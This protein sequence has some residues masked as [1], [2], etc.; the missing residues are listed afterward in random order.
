MFLV[1][2]TILGACIGSFLNVVIHRL[3]RGG[4]RAFGARSVCPACKQR[5]AWSDNLPILG[6]LRL[7]GKARCCGVR[8]AF[9]YPLVEGLTALAFAVL[10][11]APPFGVGFRFPDVQATALLAFVFHA[12][13][14]SN[15]LANT[16]IDIDFRI[17][18]DVLTFQGM[19]V[20]LAGSLV[21]PGL[22]GTF[23]VDI[24]G[25]ERASSFVFSAAGLALGVGATWAIR[26][27]GTLAFRREA[28]GLGDVKFMGAIGAFLGWQGVLYTLFLGSLLG[29]LWGSLHKLR[30]GQGE[31]YF[32]PFLA[33]GALISLFA[34]ESIHRWMFVLLPEWQ[35]T[36][37]ESSWV[38]LGGAALSFVL[39]LWMIRRGRRS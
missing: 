19:F 32:G 1:A 7:R 5:I 8:I 21:V 20:G 36:H 39:L 16:F 15:L 24:P 22:A 4:M 31:I 18:P 9:R 25:Q 12:Y 26:A 13:F 28:M 10:W 6:W 14:V 38:L 34:R 23:T 3:P 33:A 37:P 30:T 2:A 17:L 35:Q 27:L 11:A 29:A